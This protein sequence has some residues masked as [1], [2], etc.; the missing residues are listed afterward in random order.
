MKILLDTCALSEIIS[1]KGSDSLKHYVARCAPDDVFLSV[2]TLGEIMKGVELLPSGKRKLDL[3]FSLNALQ[4]EFDNRIVP[5][6]P[7]IAIL[8]GKIL[9]REKKRGHN[10]P[11]IDVLLAAT[12]IANG[13]VLVTRNTKD[14]EQTGAQLI[15]PWIPGKE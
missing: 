13:L 6:T 10:L 15:N 14:F 8:W 3:Q 1:P 7:D 11:A 4:V 9:A 12:A 2:V 5:V